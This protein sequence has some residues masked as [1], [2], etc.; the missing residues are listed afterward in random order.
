VIRLNEKVEKSKTLRLPN[1]E[2]NDLGIILEEF[3]EERR[4]GK[5]V[6]IFSEKMCLFK[7]KQLRDP[8][9]RAD[10]CFSVYFY[11]GFFPSHI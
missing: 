5:L 11:P 6:E 1:R 4:L 3:E 9:S 8:R 7:S 2:S 10:F